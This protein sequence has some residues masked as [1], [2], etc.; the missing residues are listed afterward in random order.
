M[1]EDANTVYGPVENADET[2]QA[3]HGFTNDTPVDV[4][5]NATIARV[6]AQTSSLTGAEFAAAAARRTILADGVVAP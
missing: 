5:F 2:R 1:S 3:Q 4:N 6:Q